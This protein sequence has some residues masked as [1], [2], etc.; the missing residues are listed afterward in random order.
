[1]P[2][3]KT[4]VRSGK[5]VLKAKKSQHG[6][7]DMNKVALDPR[8]MDKT[9][10]SRTFQIIQ[11]AQFFRSTRI[12]ILVCI[13]IGET[14]INNSTQSSHRIY[15]TDEKIKSYKEKAL[16]FYNKHAAFL[17]YSSGLDL[18]KKIQILM[19]GF[20][21]ILFE[22]VSGK[23]I[24]YAGPPNIKFDNIYLV[25]SQLYPGRF[26]VLKRPAAFFS[27]RHWCHK[28]LVFSYNKQRHF[29]IRLCLHCKEPDCSNRFGKTKFCLKCFRIFKSIRCYNTHIQTK[30]CEK[31]KR[32]MDCMKEYERLPNDPPHLCTINNCQ[33]C[34]IEHPMGRC[35]VLTDKENSGGTRLSNIRNAIYFDI[36]TIDMGA[37]GLK[38]VMLICGWVN[39]AT[40]RLKYK[41]F[42]KL[43]SV[44][45][46]FLEFL[47]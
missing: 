24:I 4:I 20:R 15:W 35:F 17:G 47:L 1:M 41:L 42:D 12:C 44:V 11:S 23:N 29:C 14:L 16:A 5:N 32:C 33:K 10:R 9:P 45:D 27:F 19:Q 13:L 34:C 38:P 6:K 30:L 2:N 3:S 36:E 8:L 40:G 28:C 46:D 26:D 18:I 37:G 39:K 31:L 43:N 25:E 7:L 22:R 21:I